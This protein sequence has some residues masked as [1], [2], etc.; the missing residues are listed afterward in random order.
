MSP[1]LYELNTEE[2]IRLLA[3]GGVGRLAFRGP[4]GQEIVPVNFTLL[5]DAIVCRTSPCSELG[6]DGPG[7]EAAFESDGLDPGQKSGW[8]VVARGWL[9]VVDNQAE[10]AAIK[11]A[12]D[13]KPWAGGVRHL[14]LKLVWRELTGRRIESTSS[15]L[16][17]APLV[18][19]RQLP[20]GPTQN[21]ARRAR[22]TG[23][24]PR[25]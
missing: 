23:Q 16:P 22:R 17:A 13:P 21:T 12:A 3:S 11:L 14:Y 15:T 24:P 9:Q 6:W 2:C 20:L 5:G 8:S 4:A 18:G 7:T 25:W 19:G 10:A 1:L